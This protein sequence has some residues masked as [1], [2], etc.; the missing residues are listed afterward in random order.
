[1]AVA[2]KTL[3]REKTKSAAI[4][5]D[6]L[7]KITKSAEG[8]GRALAEGTLLGSYKY[9]ELKSKKKDDKEPTRELKDLFF[10]VGE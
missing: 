1:M 8:T 10:V 3:V 4:H 9:D 6:S 5:V 7:R 2:V